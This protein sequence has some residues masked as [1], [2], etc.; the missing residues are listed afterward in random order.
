M[1]CPRLW[2]LTYSFTQMIHVSHSNLKMWKKLKINFSSPCDWFSYNKLS[3]Q[4]G[5]GKTKSI[6]FGSKLNI[7]WAEPLSIVYGNVKIKHYTKVTYLGC[8]L[9]E[10]QSGESMALH[11]LYK[12]NSRLRFLYRQ[13][14]FLNI[15]LGRLI[16]N[17]MTQP[18]FD[19][20]S[21][22]KDLKKR[23]QVSQNNCVRF[24]LQLDKK[25][26]V[27]VAEFKQINWL[28][29]NDRFSQC[30]CQVFINF[31]TVKVQNTLMKFIFL[32]NPLT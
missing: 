21:T 28:N 18:S 6:L 20:C 1:T 26:W 11:I 17:V 13:N 32:L 9:D 2:S 22:W 23:Q 25:I 14:R 30:V 8:I 4:L 3:T 10:S 19:V 31:L 15:P 7:K 29:V 16:Y 24:C 5:E 27:G 12:I